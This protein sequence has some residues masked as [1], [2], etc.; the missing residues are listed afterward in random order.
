MRIELV[1]DNGDTFEVC[2]ND[3]IGMRAV[4]DKAIDVSWDSS[5][6]TKMTLIQALSAGKVLFFAVGVRE[7]TVDSGRVVEAKAIEDEKET[8]LWRKAVKSSCR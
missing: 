4:Y 8:L 5:K 6:N 2:K 3:H 1:L 7:F